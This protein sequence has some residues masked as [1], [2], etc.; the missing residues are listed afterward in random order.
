MQIAQGPDS[1]LYLHSLWKKHSKD[2]KS[3]T[4]KEVILSKIL[5]K[6]Q[7]DHNWYIID[8]SLFIAYK[9][10]FSTVSQ[11]SNQ[12]LVQRLRK[13]LWNEMSPL[14][15]SIHKEQVNQITLYE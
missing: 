6:Q 1:N 8:C 2:I 14:E 4:K 3:I 15:G 5:K 7:H 13:F 12:C 10:Q 11:H 9:E